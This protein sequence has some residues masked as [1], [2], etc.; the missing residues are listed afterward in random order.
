M[1]KN[2]I[3][4]AATALVLTGCSSNDTFKQ[5][6]FENIPLAFNAYSNKA[7]KANIDTHTNLEFFYK[8]F[9]VYGWKSYDNKANWS[10]VFTGDINEYF[11]AADTYGQTIYLE[12]DGIK[13]AQ[14]WG[15][16]Q[17]FPAWY[18]K[19]IRYWDKF[20]TN[21]QFSA[22]T[23]I[24]AEAACT[25]DGKITIGSD[26]S[27]ITVESTNLMATPATTLAY[28]GFNKDY[29]TATSTSKDINAAVAL[30][31]SHELAKFNIKLHLD[32]GMANN[33]QDI[34]VNEVSIK[35]INGTS[36]YDSSKESA[37]GY[38]SGWKEP[39]DELEYSAKGVGVATT[40]YKMNGANAGTDNFDN[41]YIMERL[42]VPQV[43]S[44][45]T[46]ASQLNELSQACIYVKYTIGAEKFE[47]HYGLSN[48][49]ADTDTYNIQGGNEY[50]L[51]INVGPKPIYF[52]A[53]VNV[54]T[55]NEGTLTAD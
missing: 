39:I 37:A 34:V 40:G 6:V 23:P 26:G 51:T 38:L 1:K 19:G 21:Y 49:F 13:P 30:I 5:E 36:F 48:L 55:N 44:K 43:I 41:Y 18:Y 22:F 4:L 9:K 42:M 25:S 33:T 31:F 53:T 54:W 32:N 10:D 29:M 2:L 20:A 7:T 12:A 14:E 11:G 35:N 17:N 46:P 8:T 24:T 15:T 3:I 16:I 27:K 50:T 45:S 47:G 52:T 28:T